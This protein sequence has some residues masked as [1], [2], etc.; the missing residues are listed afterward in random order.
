[1]RELVQ[2]K[3]IV[4]V[5]EMARMV[6]LSRARFYQLVDAGTFPTPIYDTATR[7]PFYTEDMQMLCL[8]VR[9][10]NCGINGK[11]V[12]FYARGARPIAGAKP[13]AKAP[14]NN[15]ADLID[16]LAALGLA[17]TR[18]QV[19]AIIKELYSSGTAAVDHGEVLRAVFLRLKRRNTADNLCR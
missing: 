14:T 16:G 8:E 15:H 18:D 17:A 11:A 9:R 5:A 19:E 3:A 12:L 13:R 1:M 2:T 10:R 4:T 6:A 7:R